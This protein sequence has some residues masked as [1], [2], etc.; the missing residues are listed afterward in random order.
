MGCNQWDV[1]THG[2]ALMGLRKRPVAEPHQTPW[3][4]LV[5]QTG[6]DGAMRA[7]RQPLSTQSGD[8]A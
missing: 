5:A 1:F 7:F 8:K 4:T 2:A 3:T 6:T